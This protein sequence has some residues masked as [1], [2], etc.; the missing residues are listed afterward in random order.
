MKKIFASILIIIVFASFAACNDSG[1]QGSE[2]SPNVTVSSDVQNQNGNNEELSVES[3]MSAP[4]TDVAAF[5]YE[6]IDGQMTITNYT[7]NDTVVVIPDTIEGQSVV[8]IGDS[9]FA[10]NE[11][12]KGVV[13]PD[14][15]T[16]IERNAFCNCFDLEV[17]VAGD[18]LQF[19]GE[20]A[21][22]YCKSL[23]SVELNMGLETLELSCFTSTDE[24]KELYI[25][26]TVTTLVYPFNEAET[27]VT[28][29]SES[30]SA[31]ES[32]AKEMGISFKA[33]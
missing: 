24:L 16:R 32:Y 30:G 21:F 11:N 31:A 13:I 26:N 10:N 15:V 27:K 28:I 25:P 33:K 5:S 3:L 2:N 6:A 17:F 7:G 23:K 4:V 18:A 20:Y 29:I 12:V 8:V 22:S 9:A 1:S 14:Y 19:I